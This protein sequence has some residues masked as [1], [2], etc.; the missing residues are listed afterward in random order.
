[1]FAMIPS[2]SAKAM[3]PGVINAFLFQ[4]F[5]SS[6]WVFVLST[7]M[8]LFL[9]SM[10]ASAAILGAA[11]SMTPLFAVLQ[12]P[13]A[14]FVERVGY[15]T[16][17]VRGWASRSIFI[18][19]IAIVA[20]LPESVSP[21]LRITLTLLMMAC[22]AA[23]RGFSVCGL[24]PWMTQIIPANLRGAFIARDTMCMYLA[25]TATMLLSCWYLDAFHSVRAF[26]ALFCFSYLSAM[27]SVFF[28]R[29]IPDIQAP[30]PLAGTG[31]PPW[32]SMLLF[33]PFFRYVLFNIVLNLFVSATNVAWVPFMKDGLGFS[34]S[35][36]LGISAYSNI[37]CA[38][39]S[40]ISGPVADRVGSRP[41]MGFA[42]GLILLSLTAYMLIAAG[43]I[44]V[45]T[46]TILVIVAI[47]SVGYPMLAL[48]STRLLMG[49]IPAVGRSH[50]FAINSVAISL[51]LG[52]MPTAWGF[53]LDG[54]DRVIS[55]G[56]LF[57]PGWTW[58]RFSLVYALALAG[59]LSAQILRHRL[60][61]PRAMSTE[62]FLRILFIQSPIR[63]IS[64]VLSQLRNINL[65]GGA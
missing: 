56:F 13:A 31:R 46:L 58:N 39:A 10:D 33:P 25:L 1:M 55:Q 57:L 29:R 52:I 26:C 2:Q 62:E 15:K 22:F 65:P 18:L 8:M 47:G 21:K 60:D 64:R 19:G 34:G 50:F 3:P 11:V 14:N 4:I 30:R 7:P 40:L 23:A 27:A 61:E 48:A 17:V 63:L 35:F 24:M 43:V 51:M 53:V 5:N 37:I 38:G 54:L 12:I 28:L 45:K 32:K 20:L 59:T 49:L 9:K 6:S 42:S 16:F 36:I 41:L 44:P